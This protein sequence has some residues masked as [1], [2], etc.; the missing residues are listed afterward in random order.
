MMPT[1]FNY[2]VPVPKRLSPC[3]HWPFIAGQTGISRPAEQAREQPKSS[4]RGTC[5]NARAMEQ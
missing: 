1:L 5:S 2:Q 4:S 3:A